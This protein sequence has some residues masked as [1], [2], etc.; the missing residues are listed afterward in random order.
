MAPRLVRRTAGRRLR[1]HDQPRSRRRLLTLMRRPRAASHLLLINLQLIAALEKAWRGC[2]VVLTVGPMRS[3]HAWPFTVGVALS[4]CPL[5][6]LNPLS[7]QALL[8]LMRLGP[9][10]RPSMRRWCETA[11][12]LASTLDAGT[13]A[14]SLQLVSLAA[15]VAPKI[16]RRDEW[17]QIAGYTTVVRAE[18][19]TASPVLFAYSVGRPLRVIAREGASPASR[20]SG[21]DNSAG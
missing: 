18:P 1:R 9:R 2:S 16:E 7:D 4:G 19:T 12:S 21:V 8:R 6:G 11:G 5:Y 14:L 3:W 17:V 20:I 15:P 13:T 10:R